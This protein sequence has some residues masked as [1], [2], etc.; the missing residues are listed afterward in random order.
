MNAFHFPLEKV[1][2]LRRQQLKVEEAQFRRH[3]RTLADI[4]RRRAEYEA[5]GAAAETQ[6]R[7]W[8]PLF[9]RELH[10]LGVFRLHT[11]QQELSLA[12]PRAECQQA[13]AG[14]QKAM[15]EARRRVRLLERMKERRLAEWQAAADR[16]IE[17]LASESYLAGWVRRAGKKAADRTG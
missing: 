12:R 10:A 9:G 6:V 2:E 7:G 1:L 5:A 11:K 16:E 3:L 4:D 8:D 15:L 14:Q 13:I 17:Q